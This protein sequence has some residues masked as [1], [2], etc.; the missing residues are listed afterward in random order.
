MNQYHQETTNA[1]FDHRAVLG[2][3]ICVVQD[4]SQWVNLTREDAIARIHTIE[5][6][7][8]DLELGIEAPI[9]RE[10]V[11]RIATTKQAV[12]ALRTQIGV[13][14]LAHGQRGWAEMRSGVGAALRKLEDSLHRIV[15]L[16]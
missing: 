3:P 7:L 16:S 10:A 12:R 4:S 1:Q 13:L 5:R 8:E 15:E 11:E 6:D 2:P 9:S 14:H